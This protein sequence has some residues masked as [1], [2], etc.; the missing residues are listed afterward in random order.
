MYISKIRRFQQLTGP[1]REISQTCYEVCECM[2][3]N[4]FM[5]ITEVVSSSTVRENE[6]QDLKLTQ[7]CTVI[8][9]VL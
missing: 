4:S 3:I 7:H 1:F 6:I 9:V 2:K 8:C 5:S